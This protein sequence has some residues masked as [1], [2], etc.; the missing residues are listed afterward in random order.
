MSDMDVTKFVFRI[1]FKSLAFL[2]LAAATYW[3][4]VHPEY[5]YH[6]W[7]IGTALWAFIMVTDVADDLQPESRAPW[8]Q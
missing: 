7:Y 3:L 8:K 4:Y 2:A 6:G 1:I 5:K